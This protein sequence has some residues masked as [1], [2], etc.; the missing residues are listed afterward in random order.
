[1]EICPITTQISFRIKLDDQTGQNY[2]GLRF[3][4]KIMRFSFGATNQVPISLKRYPEMEE[5]AVLFKKCN[6]SQTECSEWH[7]HVDVSVTTPRRSV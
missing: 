5:R 6:M 3:T 4:Y 2:F 7:S 1:M